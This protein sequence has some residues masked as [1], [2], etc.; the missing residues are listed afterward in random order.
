MDNK[1]GVLAGLQA[2]RS[3]F[4]Q[5]QQHGVKVCQ[6]V[7]W[8]PDLWTGAL[9][10]KVRQEAD[11]GGIHIT[12][13]W[14]GWSGPAAWN[15]SEGPITL[16]LVPE[17]YRFQRLQELLRAGQF[18]R[19]LKVRA[20]ITHLGFIPEN[21]ND[22][23]FHDVVVAVRQV[24]QHLQSLG[25]EFWL[26]TGQETPITLL[27]L[28]QAVNTPN[29]GLNLDPAN[30]ILYGKAN[31]IDALD[32]FGGLVRNIHTKDGLYPTDPMKLGQ[33]VK[34][35]EGR[36]RYPE[37]VRRLKEIGFKGEFII[38]RE[39]TGAEQDRDIAATI[40]YLNNLLAKVEA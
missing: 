8:Q 24:A 31:P 7:S 13:F 35:G 4:T 37:F 22:P 19:R 33:E 12:A 28:I 15:F 29:L 26:E 11:E 27:R 10:E 38:E 21:A 32:I 3:C 5:L 1:I 2:E 6:L 17:A 25:L 14:A 18:A 36:V 9:A 30:L 16:G 39:I 23:V 20:V 40:S 34:V